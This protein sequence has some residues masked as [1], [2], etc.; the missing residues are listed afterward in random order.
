[1]NSYT[2]DTYDWINFNRT[3]NLT[4]IN[5]TPNLTNTNVDTVFIN[6]RDTPEKL[7]DIPPKQTTLIYGTSGIFNT[8]NTC[9]MNS[10]IQ[11]FSHNYLLT[12][13]LFVHKEEIHQ[14]LKRNAR[15]IFGNTNVFQLG[16]VSNI[17][18]IELRKKIQDPNYRPDMLTQEE[19]GIIFNHTITAQLI[20]LLE[21]LWIR[22]CVVI[23]T[24]FRKVFCEARNKFFSGYEQHDAEEAYSC[25]L[26]KMQ[27]ELAEVQNINF[28]SNKPSVQKLLEFKNNITCKMNATSNIEEKT[29][30]YNYYQKVKKEM[31]SE[32]IIINAYREMKKYFGDSYSKVTEI[33]SGFLHSSITCGDPS[34]GYSSNKFDPFLHISL[35]IPANYFM[36]SYSPNCASISIEQC[37]QEYCREEILDEQNLWMCEG[38]KKKVAAVKKL[39]LWTSPP[40]LVIQF[41][42][43]GI[44]KTSKDNRF[45]YYPTEHLDVSSMISPIY[46]DA[47]KCYKY[48]LQ[49]VIN[50]TGNMASGHY[51]TYCLDEDSG[52]WFCFDDDKVDEIP[53]SK[54][55]T[56]TAYLLFYIR[57]DMIN[58]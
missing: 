46:F 38:C 22:N 23:P 32:T 35:P 53:T 2:N 57:E 40:V 26:Q 36:T 8:C 56:N 55:I 14:I 17:V 9:Y 52:K 39:Q 27:E 50:H 5:D 20:K 1:M 25:I 12:S 33:F 30:L 42:R 4:N 15:K 44:N 28:K 10:A 11:A 18:P 49:C 34:C 6:S 54:I 41:K 48:R 16:C 45:I 21:S 51:Y 37:M 7:V 24:S 13:Y 58:N 31:P 43:F 29:S 3:Q 47:T 19:S